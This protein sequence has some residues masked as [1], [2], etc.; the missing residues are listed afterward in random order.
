[1]R[2]ITPSPQGGP[3][4]VCAHWGRQCRWYTSANGDLACHK[5]GE[6][7]LCDWCRVNTTRYVRQT[8]KCLH[9]P[10]GRRGTGGGSQGM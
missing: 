9:K 2:N 10:E 7:E 1:M 3:G 5:R 8:K 6:E 4:R